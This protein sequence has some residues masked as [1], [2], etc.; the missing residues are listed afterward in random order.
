MEY[1]DIIIKNSRVQLILWGLSQY[2]CSDPQ[3]DPHF[4]VLGKFASVSRQHLRL[5]AAQYVVG[6]CERRSL[7]RVFLQRRSLHPHNLI[8]EEPRIHLVGQINT[9]RIYHCEDHGRYVLTK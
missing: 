4:P 6:H 3:V 9:Y 2:L 7:Q 1:F 8:A 5:Y